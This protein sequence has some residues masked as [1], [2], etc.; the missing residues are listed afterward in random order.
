MI[1]EGPWIWYSETCPFCGTNITCSKV[2]IAVARE[3]IMI[4]E[5]A[6]YM[7]KHVKDKHRTVTKFVYVP[8]PTLNPKS[9]RERM[10]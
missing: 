1:N 9:V 3:E 8:R 4:R 2:P 5:L 6:H 7:T 10:T